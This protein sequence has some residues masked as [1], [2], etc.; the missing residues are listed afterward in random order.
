MKK[1]V[2]KVIRLSYQD[3]SGKRT[4][5]IYKFDGMS[6]IGSM[7]S[8]AHSGTLAEMEEIFNSD[9]YAD[10]KKIKDKN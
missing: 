2:E 1:E 9:Q 3:H 4:Y 10:Y 8:I 6:F 7:W 5:M